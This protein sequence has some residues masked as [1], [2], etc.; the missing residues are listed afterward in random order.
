MWF[1]EK[2]IRRFY[3]PRDYN[4]GLTYYRKGRVKD[5]RL[6]RTNGRVQVTCMVQVICRDGKN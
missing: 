3:G 5:L 2:Y 1:D 6:D 4:N